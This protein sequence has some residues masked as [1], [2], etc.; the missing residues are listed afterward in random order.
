LYWCR[1]CQQH[2]DPHQE[3]QTDDTPMDPHPAAQAYLAG[4]PWNRDAS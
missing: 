4:L 2:L 1:G 3:V